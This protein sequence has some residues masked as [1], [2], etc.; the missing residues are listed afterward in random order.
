MNAPSTS[1]S[2]RSGNERWLHASV[3]EVCGMY[4]RWHQTHSMLWNIGSIWVTIGQ[5]WNPVSFPQTEHTCVIQ[6]F[7]IIGTA[8]RTASLTSNTADCCPILLH[9]NRKS[10]GTKDQIV[11]I[12]WIIEQGNFRKTST[13]VSLNMLKPLCGSQ[14]TVESS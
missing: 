11:N 9:V 2:L 8:K 7:P 1:L 13:A 3:K 12:H 10:R 5:V 14:Q 6:H 4:S